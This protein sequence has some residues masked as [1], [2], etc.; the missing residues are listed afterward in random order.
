[1]LCV[2]AAPMCSDSAVQ[3]LHAVAVCAV[4]VCLCNECTEPVQSL[5]SDCSFTACHWTQL[6]DTDIVGVQACTSDITSELQAKQKKKCS[7]LAVL[8]KAQQ[9]EAEGIW[10]LRSGSR[11]L[12][13]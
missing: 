12:G 2:C 3:F 13:L 11:G 8:T 9:L 6:L 4:L 5:Y 7:A 1:M 10:C